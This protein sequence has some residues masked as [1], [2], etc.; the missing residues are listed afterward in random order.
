MK[1]LRELQRY[2]Q[3]Q[4]RDDRDQEV[5][6]F[7]IENAEMIAGLMGVPATAINNAIATVPD[8]A[9]LVRKALNTIKSKIEKAR[10][11]K[12]EKRVSTAQASATALGSVAYWDGDC[13]HFDLQ[14]LLASVLTNHKELLVFE[15]PDGFQVVISMAPMINLAKLE[16]DDM[17]GYVDRH[18]VRIRWGT[19]GQLNFVHQLHPEPAARVVF[20]LPS[21]M[22]CAAE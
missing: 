17:H 1:N 11:A 10:E 7:M 16:R 12:A 2:M 19:K 8:A 18:G 20:P 21:R 9:E 13:A 6:A 4:H 3:I 15:S 22:A 5:R 14:S